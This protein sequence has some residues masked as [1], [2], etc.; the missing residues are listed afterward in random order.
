METTQNDE[1]TE[2]AIEYVRRF[3]EIAGTVP[4]F[5]IHY[6][7]FGTGGTAGVTAEH[8]VRYLRNLAAADGMHY[9]YR[10]AIK[11]LTVEVSYPEH[12]FG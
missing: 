10:K 11:I 5:D 1:L 7:G 9:R 6:E 2:A 12:I 8:A 4:R 3:E